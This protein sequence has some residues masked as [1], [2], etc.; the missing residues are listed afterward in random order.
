MT[1]QAYYDR[2]KM[3][4][5][6]LDERRD[7]ADIDFQHRFSL[8]NCHEIIWGLGYR[9]T[10]DNIGN[11]F[12]FRFDPREKNEDIISGFLQDDIAIGGN[13]MHLTLGSKFEYNDYTGFEIQPNIRLLYKPEDRYSLWAAVSRARER[14]F[15]SS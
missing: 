8:E 15:A 6:S 14:A 13:E 10:R 5:P 3:D 4:D 1:L 9:F 7:T 12:S 2:T 11:T